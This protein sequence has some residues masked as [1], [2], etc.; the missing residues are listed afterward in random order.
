MNPLELVPYP[1]TEEE[2]AQVIAKI[3]SAVYNAII[4]K[5]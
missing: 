1:G 5:G 2:A 3:S 4:H